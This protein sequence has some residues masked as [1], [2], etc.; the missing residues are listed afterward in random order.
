MCTKICFAVMTPQNQESRNNLLRPAQGSRCEPKIVHDPCPRVLDWG[1]PEDVNAGD[2]TFS[3]LEA[4][5]EA[6]ASEI[7]LTPIE[8]FGEVTV[9][10]K[11]GSEYIRQQSLTQIQFGFI[12][13]LL[14]HVATLSTYGTGSRPSPKYFY[15]KDGKRYYVR[16]SKIRLGDQATAILIKLFVAGEATQPIA[17]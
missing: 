2:F 7:Q 5:L 9:H 13:I 3:V 17:Q 10:F 14:S 15:T 16:F 11:I 12:A 4:A 1:V 6:G 8:E